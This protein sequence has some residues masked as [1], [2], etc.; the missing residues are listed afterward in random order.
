MLFMRVIMVGLL[1]AGRLSKLP[2]SVVGFNKI[3]W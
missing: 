1:L 3:L 2:V